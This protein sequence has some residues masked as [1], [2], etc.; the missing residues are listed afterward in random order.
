MKIESFYLLIRHWVLFTVK[1]PIT[2]RAHKKKN[3]NCFLYKLLDIGKKLF[4]C[5][6]D[7]ANLQMNV[8]VL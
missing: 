4:M 3:T 2:E 6:S 5:F 8:V 7:H 1:Q